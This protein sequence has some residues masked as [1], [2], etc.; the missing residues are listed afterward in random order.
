MVH[1]VPG[2]VALPPIL[3]G[4]WHPGRFHSPLQAATTSGAEPLGNP[5]GVLPPSQTS[6]HP[7]DLCAVQGE[8]ES[9]EGIAHASSHSKTG[10]TDCT[11]PRLGAHYHECQERSGAGRC[12]VDLGRA[13]SG[14]QR[15]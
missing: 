10:G 14:A 15:W 12:L 7:C 6:S 13:H 2:L 3:P 8:M 11:P 9:R 1:A 5:S 4:S